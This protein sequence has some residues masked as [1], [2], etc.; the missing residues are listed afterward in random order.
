MSS[1]D[2]FRSSG[3]NIGDAGLT[4]LCV[5]LGRNTTLTSLDLSGECVAGFFVFVVV[6]H[7]FSE[8]F[9]QDCCDFYC[10]DLK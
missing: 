1:L 7:M 8:D 2:P 10:L 9:E 4:S 3:N 5:A 6:E